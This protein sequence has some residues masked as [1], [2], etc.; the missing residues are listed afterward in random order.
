MSEDKKRKKLTKKIFDELVL[1]SRRF[2]ITIDIDIEEIP[3]SKTIFQEALE[4]LDNIPTHNSDGFDFYLDGKERYLIQKALKQAEKYD[5]KSYKFYKQA[6]AQM[7]FDKELIRSL[8]DKNKKIEAL[9][10]L[11][12]ERDFRMSV[13]LDFY[14]NNDGHKVTKEMKE[15]LKSIN[16]MIMALENGK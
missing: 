5:E 6:S 1:D 11:Y 3:P 7:D 2:N 12:V 15:R 10:D 16:K 14:E 4:V 8:K 9:K 13:M